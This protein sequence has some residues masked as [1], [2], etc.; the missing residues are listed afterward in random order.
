VIPRASLERLIF[1]FSGIAALLPEKSALYEAVL[2]IVALFMA[3]QG[4]SMPIGEMLESLQAMM[5]KAQKS[6]FSRDSD[7][8]QANVEVW[9]LLCTVHALLRLSQEAR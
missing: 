3:V 8:Q 1:I 6:L 4:K 7:V 2:E 9:H 5:E